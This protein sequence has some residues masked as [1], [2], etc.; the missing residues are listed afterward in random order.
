M[1]RGTGAGTATAIVLKVA[2]IAG[3]VKASVGGLPTSMVHAVGLVP[4]LPAGS[5]LL[6]RRVVRPGEKRTAMKRLVPPV[7][8]ADGRVSVRVMS[9]VRSSVSVRGKLSD[10]T[11]TS[12]IAAPSVS[13]GRSSRPQLKMLS[14]GGTEST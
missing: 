9:P 6:S 12:L 14:C 5:V 2:P 3:A 1:A 13:V 7:P 4:M 11:V 8:V 10:D